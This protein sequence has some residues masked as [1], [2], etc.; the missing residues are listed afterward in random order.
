MSAFGQDVAVYIPDPANLMVTTRG[1]RIDVHVTFHAYW[2]LGERR[3]IETVRRSL[4]Y[5]TLRGTRH[6]YWGSKY[7][8]NGIYITRWMIREHFKHVRDSH[9]V[10]FDYLHERGLI[11]CLGK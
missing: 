10:A 2:R 8:C 4:Y 7:I 3:W 1:N 9:P 6:P 11:T 5:A